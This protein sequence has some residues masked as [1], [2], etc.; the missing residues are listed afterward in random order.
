MLARRIKRDVA[1]R[2]RDT[3]GILD[4]Y[5]RFVKPAYDA[6]VLPTA[7]YADM[8]LAPNVSKRHPT[9]V[10]QSLDCPWLQ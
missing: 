9:D 7:R 1:E 6:F 10:I 4:Q 3:Q 5:L 2:G 8:V